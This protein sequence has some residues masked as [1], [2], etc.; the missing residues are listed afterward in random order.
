[1]RG[2]VASKHH[3][4]YM[5][6]G[7]Y[8]GPAMPLVNRFKNSSWHHNI[9]HSCRFQGGYGVIK[10]IP[11]SIGHS[12]PNLHHP[13]SILHARFRQEPRLPSAFNRGAI[14][15]GKQ[16]TSRATSTVLT[17]KKVKDIHSPLHTIPVIARSVAMWQS[18]SRLTAAPSSAAHQ[19]A[20]QHN[21]SMP[22]SHRCPPR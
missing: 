19:P 17:S 2:S 14:V 20:A 1:M 12:R 10:R 11:N 8:I 13:Q 16:G 4:V 22:A 6:N 15:A 7:L 3:H 9:R 21:R 5:P 18:S